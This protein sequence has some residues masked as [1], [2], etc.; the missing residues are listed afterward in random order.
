M[1]SGAITTFSLGLGARGNM[2]GRL[3]TRPAERRPCLST[4]WQQRH[5]AALECRQV[6][7]EMQHEADDR[8][9]M[10]PCDFYASVWGDFFLHHPRS[11]ASSQQQ[12]EQYP[13]LYQHT[14]YAFSSYLLFQGNMGR[15]YLD[16]GY[17]LPL[18]S[19]PYLKFLKVACFL[20]LG[21]SNNR[22]ISKLGRGQWLV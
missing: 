8:L 15:A 19:T 3:A 10:N 9:N 13:S 21:I 5:G 6:S 20:F 22:Y 11:A 4:S 7:A 14:L 12:V 17:T 16:V 18:S 2:S 1:Q